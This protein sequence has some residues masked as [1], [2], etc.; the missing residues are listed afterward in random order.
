[1][2]TFNWNKLPVAKIWGKKNIWSLVIKNNEGKNS[3][4]QSKIINFNEMENMFCQPTP[5]AA[6]GGS[7]LA[8]GGGKDNKDSGGDKDKKKDDV[9]YAVTIA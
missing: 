6:N 1:M 9:S 5:S 4:A 7:G 3:K 2:R 8:N